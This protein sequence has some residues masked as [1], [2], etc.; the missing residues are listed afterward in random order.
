MNKIKISS[1][2]K[3][4]ISSIVILFSFLFYLSVPALYDYESVQ[5]QIKSELSSKFGLNVGVSKNIKYRILPSPHFE[6][7]DSKL[8]TSS[9][10]E[11]KLIGELKNSKVF[12]S[13][14]N[15][16]NQKYLNV[17][18]VVFSKSI[19]NFNKKNIYFLNE[20]INEKKTDRNIFIKKSKF[21]FRDNE[22]TIAIFPI[23][24][25]KFFYNKKKSLNLVNLN[26]IAFNSKFSFNFKKEFEKEKEINF[27]LK[28]PAA[29]LSV[30]N[31]LSNIS[32]E[33]KKFNSLTIVNFLGS[34]I[35]TQSDFSKNLLKFSSKKSKVLNNNLNYSGLIYFKPFYFN[36]NINIE[37][38]NWKKILS[39]NFFVSV[40]LQD[41]FKIHSNFNSKILLNI[42]SFFKSKIFKNGKL[43]IETQNGKINFN[44]SYMNLKDFGKV[45][46]T[47]S[48]LFSFQGSTIFKS[49]ILLNVDKNRKFYNAFQVPKNNRKKFNQI[50]FTI[51]NNLS[52][53]TTKVSNIIIDSKEKKNLAEEINLIINNSEFS[54]IE[55]TSNWIETKSFINELIKEINLV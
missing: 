24:N 33:E 49:D 37:N 55:N 17:K 23:R 26:G 43:Y 52:E 16:H 3:L 18:E 48:S 11:P 30:K 10:S 27:I 1:F 38:W 8:Y 14:I 46:F 40:L 13:I 15:L 50:K 45:T 28:L 2:N 34:E 47:N 5:K 36:T 39:N 6:I 54:L 4:I 22:K 19:F 35:K 53:K 32:K 42:D 7:Y 51:E 31:V 21:F 9:D 20:S 29:N 44:N 25:L 12:V 41:N